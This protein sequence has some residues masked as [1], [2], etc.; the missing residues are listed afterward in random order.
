MRIGRPPL[1]RWHAVISIISGR[2]DAENAGVSDDWRREREASSLLLGT[3]LAH[4]LPSV[5]D[6]DPRFE[7]VH[8]LGIGQGENAAEFR[9]S[10]W[11][12]VEHFFVRVLQGG[13]AGRF[14]HD[15]YALVVVLEH[16]A[17][18]QLFVDIQNH[19]PAHNLPSSRF[20]RP[21][22]MRRWLAVKRAEARAMR[23]LERKYPDA[24]FAVTGDA[25]A[26]QDA[27]WF[28]RAMSRLFPGF[29]NGD[30]FE[31]GAIWIKGAHAAWHRTI[32]AHGSDHDIRRIGLTWVTRWPLSGGKA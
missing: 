28:L 6:G 20:W 26:P 23:E 31:F 25:N 14:T 19:D 17:S 8:E 24:I 15:A 5:L 32:S 27:P 29:H 13:G 30:G 4:R 12:L 1:R 18:G 9:H 10:T 7:L 11:R 22:N 3:E 21:G 16:L 2:Y